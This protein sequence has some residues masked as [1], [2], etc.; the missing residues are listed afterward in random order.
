MNES[1]SVEILWKGGVGG[2]R[3]KGREEGEKEEEE[4]RLRGGVTSTAEIKAIINGL[5]I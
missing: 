4:R 1:L 3:G 5:I 2:E